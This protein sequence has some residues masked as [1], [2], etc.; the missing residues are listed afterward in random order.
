M[1]DETKVKGYALSVI[2]DPEEPNLVFLGTEHG[3]WI[4]VDNG[5][6]WSQFKNGFPSVSTMDLAIQEPES[7]LIIGTF[8]RAIWVLDDLLSLREIAA[9]RLQGAITA[10]PVNDAVQVKGLFINP[11]GNIWTG[12]HTTFEGKNR[13]FQK[14]KIPYYLTELKDSTAMVTA[15]IY[16]ENNEWLNTIAGDSL[17]VG[18]NYLTWHLDEKSASLPGASQKIAV[19]PGTY[20]VAIDY[21]GAIDS[22]SVKVIPDPRFD[23]TTE[24]DEDLYAFRK[25]LDGQ[26]VALSQP[27]TA[28]DKHLTVLKELTALAGNAGPNP[29]KKAMKMIQDM[30]ARL[31]ALRAKGQTPK[32][33]RQVGAWMSF[34]TTPF[35]MLTDLLLV[36]DARTTLISDQHQENFETMRKAIGYFNGEVQGLLTKDWPIFKKEVQKSNLK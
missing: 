16:N 10:L 7:A 31:N 36:A 1:I 23:L 35:S 28:I 25:K 32:P 12:F 2:Q 21:A 5:N 15:S 17:V 11:P 27:L 3:L 20:T 13:V 22:T 18:L 24:V 6:T 34:E 29:T 14:T 33:K 30:E 4:S 19:L 26:V 9:N 8:G